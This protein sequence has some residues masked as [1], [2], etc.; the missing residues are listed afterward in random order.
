MIEY[1]SS[2]HSDVWQT[3]T[4]TEYSEEEARDIE[5]MYDVMVT[6]SK[7]AGTKVMQFIDLYDTV[8]HREFIE[9]AHRLSDSK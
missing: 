2:E 7:V 8:Y 3:L 5:C 1:I 6:L 9:I 4:R